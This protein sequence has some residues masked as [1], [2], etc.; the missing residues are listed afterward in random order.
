MNT[1]LDVPPTDLVTLKAVLAAVQHVL[2]QKIPMEFAIADVQERYRTLRL[3]GIE[4]LD[5]T[6][7]TKAD[8]LHLSWQATVDAAL[9]RDVR[10][11]KV[12][13]QFTEV[14]KADVAAFSASADELRTA[15]HATGPTSLGITLTQGLAM[16]ADFTKRLAGA[17]KQREGLMNA[18][19]L[20]GLAMTRYPQLQEVQDDMDHVA[21]L[22]TLY[23]DLTAF[24]ETNS[25]MLWADLDSE[26]HMRRVLPCECAH[27][28]YTTRCS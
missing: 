2:D 6:E 27:C 4:G 9:T 25:N 17:Y 24:A 5:A 16:M 1:A 20:F 26:W 14:T 13:A 11:V 21:P 19:R 3:H 7:V 10:L 8:A 18:E 22:Y 23:A 15:Y 12:K 28:V